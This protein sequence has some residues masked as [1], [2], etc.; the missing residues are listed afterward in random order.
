M[1]SILCVIDD[2][3]DIEKLR[4]FIKKEAAQS[5]PNCSICPLS[6]NDDLIHRAREAISKYADVR[7]LPFIKEF[8]K[9]A[10]LYK[11]SFIKF[12]SDFSKRGTGQSA[13]I[14]RYFMHP[15]KDFSLWWLSLIREKCT[16]KN[17]SYHNLIKLITIIDFR[18]R[19]TANMIYVD[20][21]DRVLSMAVFR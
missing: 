3:V 18:S 13:S 12:M 15:T 14:I 21:D 8:H 20:I 7:V 6:V 5:R 10:F 17:R 2:K 16:F 9:N 11:D 1:K 4:S 19:Y